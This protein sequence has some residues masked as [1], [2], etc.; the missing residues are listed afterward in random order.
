MSPT[1]SCLMLDLI[2]LHYKNAPVLPDLPLSAAN[3]SLKTASA[4]F[5]SAVVSLDSA[6]MTIW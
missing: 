2:G 6:F 5:N 4:L 1:N 3:D